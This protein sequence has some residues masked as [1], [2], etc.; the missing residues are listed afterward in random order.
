M[1]GFSLRL[2]ASLALSAAAAY[3]AP[4]PGPRTLLHD[5]SAP[6]PPSNDAFYACGSCWAFCTI[7]VLESQASHQILYRTTD[8]LGNATATVLTVLVPH[9]ADLAK[10]LS[11][12]V[13]ED[14]ATADCPPSHALQLAAATGP[15]LATIATQAELWLIEAMTRRSATDQMTPYNPLTCR[16]ANAGCSI[17]LWTL[18]SSPSASNTPM[19]RPCFSSVTMNAGFW[20]S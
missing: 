10:V 9:G 7:A 15:A 1:A 2:V 4:P 14:A 5:G 16:K 12:Q 3:A 8:S 6:V 19:P 20:K 17:F 18:W 11:Y 13:A